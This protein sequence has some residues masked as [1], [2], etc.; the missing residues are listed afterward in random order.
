MVDDP[1]TREI[2]TLT[3]SYTFFRAVDQSA[4]R[5]SGL[6]QRQTPSGAAREE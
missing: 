2:E 1:D 5:Q 6:N 4:A 3:L